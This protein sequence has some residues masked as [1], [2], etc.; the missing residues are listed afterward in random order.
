MKKL[1]GLLLLTIC[2]KTFSLN[3][4]LYNPCVVNQLQTIN[5]AFHGMFDGK[6]KKSGFEAGNMSFYSSNL[7]YMFGIYPGFISGQNNNPDNSYRYKE[8]AFQ[9][10]FFISGFNQISDRLTLGYGAALNRTMVDNS[11]VGTGLDLG[12]SVIYANKSGARFSVG[13]NSKL[14]HYDY[15][16]IHLFDSVSN[17]KANINN[18]DIGLGYISRN[19]L[20]KAGLS[21]FNIREI[22]IS[23]SEFSGGF[24]G[25]YSFTTLPYTRNITLNLIKK[26]YLN[27]SRTFALDYSLYALLSQYDGID[28]EDIMINTGIS[29][30]VKKHTFGTGITTNSFF[31]NPDFSNVGL[32]LKYSGKH[33]NLMY[34]FMYSNEAIFTGRNTYQSLN[35]LSLKYVL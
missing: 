23:R 4:P 3:V 30:T 24:E 21:C 9:N 1:A 25:S 22:S 35:Y 12:I 14:D 2:T 28:I 6:M 8:N 18:M 10:N 29:K 11:S 16:F 32:Y 19:G 7:S 34:S 5:P 13:V 17:E 31:Y 15:T 20:F 33:I 27:R 26:S